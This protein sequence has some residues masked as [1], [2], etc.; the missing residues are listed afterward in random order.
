MKTLTNLEIT[1]QVNQK[2]K[3]S[4]PDRSTQ[5]HPAMNSTADDQA[6]ISSMNREQKMVVPC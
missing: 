6:S 3:L 2:A 5:K 1:F 4:A